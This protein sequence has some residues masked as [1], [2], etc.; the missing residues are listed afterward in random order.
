MEKFSLLFSMKTTKESNQYTLEGT[1]DLKTFVDVFL[2][3]ISQTSCVAF[4]GEMGSG[5]TTL[6]SEIL[7]A[8]GIDNPQGS[9]T[10]SI[11]Q[12]YA[13]PTNQNCYHLDAYRIENTQEA[14]QIGLEEL[15]EEDAFFFVEWPEKIK[16]FLPINTIWLYI[17]EIEQNKRLITF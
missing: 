8:M 3:K 7:K 15:F 9:P 17:R 16:E 6:I 5:K 13:L 12:S 11:I 2:K 4:S 1:D 10:Y 14:Y